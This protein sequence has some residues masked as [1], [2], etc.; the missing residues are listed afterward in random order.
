METI[1][2]E[3]LSLDITAEMPGWRALPREARD[4]AY[5]ATV[6]AI[7]GWLN[8]EWVHPDWKKAK[9]KRLRALRKA[10]RRGRATQVITKARALS[11]GAFDLVPF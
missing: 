11:P 10:V 5:A 2:A 7:C 4:A 1:A 9:M 8:Q 3:A 6:D